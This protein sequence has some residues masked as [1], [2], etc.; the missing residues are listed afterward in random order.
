M[1]QRAWMTVFGFAVV[2]CLTG[3]A[4]NKLTRQNFDMVKEGVS[5]KLEVE[6]TLGKQFADRGD[7]WQYENEDEHLNAYIYWDKA[8]KVE[9][10]EWI[11]AKTGE[12]TGAAPGIKEH[13][14]GRQASEQKSNMTIKKE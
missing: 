5:T 9:R 8:G 2:L 3:C 6:N 10:K 11:D 13:P 7:C 4:E 12:W 1:L 14:E